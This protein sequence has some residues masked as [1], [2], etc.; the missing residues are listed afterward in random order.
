MTFVYADG[1]RN[2]LHMIFVGMLDG[3]EARRMLD[4]AKRALESLRP[5]FAILTDLRDLRA[6]K[7][8]AIK[9]IEELMDL[10]NERGL[11]KVVRVLPVETENFGFAIMS[12]FH[13]SHDV[14][15]VT[16]LNLEEAG[17]HLSAA[18]GSSN[19]TPDGIRQATD[20]LPPDTSG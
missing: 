9:I 7:R 17:A 14:H 3:A 2:L 6:V 4:A 12:F 11:G 19:H 15:V 18:S 5:G 1:S 13:Y 10:C 16:C 8:D 20:G